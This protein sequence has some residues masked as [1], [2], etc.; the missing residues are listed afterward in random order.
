M[1]KWIVIMKIQPNIYLVDC[2]KPR[3]N[4]SQVGRHRDS[5]PG[6]PECESRALHGATSLG[7]VALLFDRL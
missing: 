3:K 7:S 1:V 5:N 6:S 2:G 4:H